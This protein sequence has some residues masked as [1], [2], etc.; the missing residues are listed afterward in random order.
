MKKDPI[1]ILLVDDDRGDYLIVR[2]LLARIQNWALILDWVASY[3][4]DEE[5]RAAP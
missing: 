3:D 2:Q 5:N 1:R 4:E